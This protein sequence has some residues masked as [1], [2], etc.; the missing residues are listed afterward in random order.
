MPESDLVVWTERK[1]AALHRR[2]ILRPLHRARL[3][4]YDTEKRTARISPPGIDHVERTIIGT[5]T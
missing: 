3:I 5:A 2:D 1:D 4:E